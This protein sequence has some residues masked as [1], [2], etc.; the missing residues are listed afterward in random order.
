MDIAF[1][2]EKL[3]F[4]QV[5]QF[6]QVVKVV[7]H[8]DGHGLSALQYPDGGYA[9]YGSNWDVH[10]PSAGAWERF[11]VPASG[12]GAITAYRDGGVTSAFPCVP[13]VVLD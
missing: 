9:S 2:L 10:K 5:P 11:V 6:N 8:P 12:Q 7:P 13:V 3:G 1:D 4:N